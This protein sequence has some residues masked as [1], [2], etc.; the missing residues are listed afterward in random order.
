M[1]VGGSN[2]GEDSNRG[3]SYIISNWLM[4]EGRK[5]TVMTSYI[6]TFCLTSLKKNIYRGVFGGGLLQY[7]IDI[8]IL[9]RFGEAC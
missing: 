3:F 9:T 6:A 4:E 8:A 2:L 1:R 5:P 7:F